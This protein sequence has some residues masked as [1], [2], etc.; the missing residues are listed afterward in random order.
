MC[1]R[2]MM[3]GQS[4]ELLSTFLRQ[5]GLADIDVT[6][7]EDRGREFACYVGVNGW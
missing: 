1:L 7:E 2:E 3:A 6:R 5:T 4:A